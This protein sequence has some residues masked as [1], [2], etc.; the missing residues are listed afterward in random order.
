M[1]GKPI[2]KIDPY[3]LVEPEIVHVPEAGGL[4]V[5]TTVGEGLH[6]H[7]RRS[8]RRRLISRAAT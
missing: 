2:Y 4:F 3:N 7:P 5:E 8:F 6:A 1:E